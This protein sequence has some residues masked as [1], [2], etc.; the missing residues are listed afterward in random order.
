PLAGLGY[1][2]PGRTHRR[3]G[4]PFARVVA[5]A[6]RLLQSDGG[7]PAGA[8]GRSAGILPGAGHVVG[9]GL[10]CRAG[11]AAFLERGGP[12]ADRGGPPV[13]RHAPRRRVTSAAAAGP[14][15][16]LAG[17]ADAS[18]QNVPAARASHPARPQ[19]TNGTRAAAR[20]TCTPTLR[21]GP[22]RQGTSRPA[23]KKTAVR[24][25]LTARHA[26]RRARRA[27]R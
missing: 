12:A 1:H 13:L 7:R 14:P 20:C 3:A 2:C 11:P 17:A 18:E 8:A 22:R 4:R 10:G 6:R 21:L 24:D 26:A 15:G 23:Q 9:P 25:G 27:W 5:A 19:P 16:P